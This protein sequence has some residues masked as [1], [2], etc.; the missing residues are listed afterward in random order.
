MLPVYDDLL[1]LGDTIVETRFG[2]MLGHHL[3]F[4]WSH[5]IQCRLQTAK[6]FRHQFFKVIDVKKRENVKSLSK[7][8]GVYGSNFMILQSLT[9]E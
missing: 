7:Q 3:C 8:V 9:C 2:R 4:E 1:L 5:S 6:E